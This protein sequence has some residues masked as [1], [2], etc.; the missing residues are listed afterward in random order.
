MIP[1][2]L[3]NLI[4]DKLPLKTLINNGDFI[5]PELNM[6]KVKKYWRNSDIFILIVDNDINGVKYLIAKNDGENYTKN[7]LIEMVK[8]SCE[9]DRLEII[10]FLLGKQHRNL[11]SNPLSKNSYKFLSLKTSKPLLIAIAKG[12]LDIVKYLIEHLIEH[13]METNYTSINDYIRCN[14]YK[15][16]TRAVK[17]DHSDILKYLVEKGANVKACEERIIELSIYNGNLDML[18]YLVELGVNIRFKNDEALKFACLY[19]ELD[20]LKY[21]ISLGLDIR[22]KCEQLVWMVKRSAYRYIYIIKYLESLNIESDAKP[23]ISIT[24]NLV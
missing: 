4:C 9:C 20:I 14:E 3:I 1:L 6:K 15:P 13:L 7:D 12:Y 2:E 18:K 24:I 19:G 10:K 17:H 23:D 8:K 21:L 11:Y 22:K 5:L 16:I